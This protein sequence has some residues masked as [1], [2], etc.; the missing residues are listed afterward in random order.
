MFA[1]D[2]DVRTGD[3]HAIVDAQTGAR[4]NHAR[5]IR[6]GNHVWIAAHCIILKGVSI[7]DNSVV[8]TGSVVAPVHE[9]GVIVAGNPAKIVKRG[10]S[11]TRS[12]T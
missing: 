4:I 10:I 9:E 12:R 2:I 11:W 5:D 8:G 7:A 3:S 1:Y 6:I